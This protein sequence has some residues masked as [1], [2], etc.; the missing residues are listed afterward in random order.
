M[1][2]QHHPSHLPNGNILVFDNGTRAGRSRVVEVDP[3]TKTIV[4]QYGTHPRET[5][6][7]EFAG[8]CERLPDG[9]TLI[10]VAEDGRAFEITPDGRTVWR[11]QTRKEP[12]T[13][14]TSRVTFYRLAGVPQ[15]VLAHLPAR[16]PAAAPDRV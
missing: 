11:W 4:W 14:T 3:V 6:F 13:R 16:V 12:S 1:S 5:F 7:S 8:S 2:G 10:A 15:S 9:N